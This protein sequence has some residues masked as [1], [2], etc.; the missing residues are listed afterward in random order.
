MVLLKSSVFE[1]NQVVE[2]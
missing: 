2:V 1:K